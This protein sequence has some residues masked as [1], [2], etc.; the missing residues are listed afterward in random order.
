MK[1]RLSLTLVA[2]FV[3]ATSAVG[4]WYGVFQTPSRYPLL[5]QADQ[6]VIGKSIVNSGGGVG[7]DISVIG[8]GQ[9]P[10]TG[11]DIRADGAPGQS[12]TGLQVIQNG[13]GTGMRITVG[14]DGPATGVRVTVGSH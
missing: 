14:G 9:E 11:L 1:L 7:A 6:Q 2:L 10:K 13:P 12:V 8:S 3:S 5:A 4:T